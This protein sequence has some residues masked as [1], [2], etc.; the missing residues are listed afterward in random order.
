MTVIVYKELDQNKRLNRSTQHYIKILDFNNIPYVLTEYNDNLLEK[1]RSATAFV[2]RFNFYDDNKRLG[3][4]LIDLIEKYLDVPCYP[5]ANLA[6]SFDDKIR[7][8]FLL[9]LF[10]LPT[11]ETKVFFDKDDAHE[12]LESASFPMIFKLK[13]GAGSMNVM[14]L[15]SK[16]DAKK[17][18]E[19]MFSKGIEPERSFLPGT[20][21]R[22]Y[23]DYRRE[24]H[25]FLGDIYRRFKGLDQSPVYNVEKNYFYVQKFLK[26]NAFDVR[27]T[28]INGK[29]FGYR[30]FNRDGD[31]RAS[32]S[33]KIDYNNEE[34]PIECIEISHKLA[35]KLDLVCVA[36]D[37]LH[38]DG[39]YKIIEFSYTFIS[40][41]VATC[42]GYWTEDLVY[43]EGSY[44]PEYLQLS[45][46]LQNTEFSNLEQPVISEFY[47]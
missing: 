16:R 25:R 47:D 20:L 45:W 29:A 14:L 3:F 11:I 18:V 36:I 39:E 22:E 32:G 37:F 30:R 26:D 21:R 10:N 41:Y 8:M 6:Y 24:A 5:T 15:K 4:T 34:I 40:D 23:F 1:I 28:V 43:H 2:F 19:T 17:Y 42:P 44:I 35:R 33:G 31:F 46:L 38:D 12:F 9:E 7:Q 27:V 13:G